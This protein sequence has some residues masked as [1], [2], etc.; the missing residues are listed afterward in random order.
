MWDVWRIKNNKKQ[1]QSHIK[2]WEFRQ[3]TIF[4]FN[5]HIVRLPSLLAAAGASHSTCAVSCKPLI[6]SCLF[7]GTAAM[8]S[9]PLPWRV[10]THKHTHLNARTHS[11][12]PTLPY[13]HTPRQAK[14]IKCASVV[15]AGLMNN[16][17]KQKTRPSFYY[18]ILCGGRGRRERDTRRGK[19]SK[20][21][22][23]GGGS[24]RPV[25]ALLGFIHAAMW[26]TGAGS[27]TQM[28]THN[29]VCL[30]VCAH[31]ALSDGT[32]IATC[33][34]HEAHKKVGNAFYWAPF[35]SCYME[36]PKAK[37]MHVWEV[38]VCGGRSGGG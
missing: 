15:A 17:Q 22:R 34:I 37:K 23:H 1:I 9:Y 35:A 11:L 21:K 25:Y 16:A 3:S 19:E 28:I 10:H 26:K 36:P 8:Q 4:V 32:S 30:G 27:Y 12:H 5:T 2:S 14:H 29:V 20:A 38:C 31:P 6:S 33:F 13:S 18:L 7:N 24:W